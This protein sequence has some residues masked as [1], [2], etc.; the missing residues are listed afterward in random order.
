MAN[1]DAGKG[2]G[3]GAGD[4]GAGGGGAGDGGAGGAGAA[5]AAEA[6]RAAASAAAAAAAGKGEGS[7]DAGK[8]DAGAADDKGGKKDPGWN[9]TWRQDYA[10]K[11]EKLLKRLERYASPKAALDALIAAQNKISS[12]EVKRSLPD[13]P[14]AE[15]LTEYRKDN[16]IPDKPEGYLENLPNGLVIGDDDKPLFESFVK[17]LHDLNSDPKIA[18]YAVKWYNDFRET[19]ITKQA[20]RDEVNKSSTEDALRAEW[21]NDYRTNV[22]SIHGLLDAAQPEVAEAVLNARMADGTALLNNPQVMRWLT[23]MAREINPVHSIVPGSGGGTGAMGSIGD[24]IGKIETYMKNE[25]A[26][27]NKDTKAQERLRELYD[28]RSKL[29]S[30]SAA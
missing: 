27:Y 13:K 28:A 30:R 1:E 24:E 9:E 23:S 14:T 21:G 19:E 10:G 16:G 8:G 5:A 18:A 4:G 11:D 15:E 6:A 3:S 20:E 12:G 7:G 25:R 22:N 26:K 17:G 29:Q 2:T